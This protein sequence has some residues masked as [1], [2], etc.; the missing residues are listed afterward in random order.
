[1][2]G[3]AK[4]LENAGL[5]DKNQIL[6]ATEYA[7]KTNQTFQSSIIR[8]GFLGFEKLKPMAELC[9]GYP[10][11]TLAKPVEHNL[12]DP[13]IAK[14]NHSYAYERNNTIYLIMDDPCD[15]I[16]QDRV[17]QKINSHLPIKVF[18][19]PWAIMLQWFDDD[20]I[21]YKNDLD[22]II[23]NALQRGATDIHFFCEKYLVEVR[24]RELGILLKQK[25]LDYSAYQRL[26]LQTKMQCNLDIVEKRKPQSGS[27]LHQSFHAKTECR[28]SLHPAKHGES[29]VIRLFPEG[30]KSI[31]LEEL[32]FSRGIC[33]NLRELV[34][35][36]SGLIIVAGPTGGGKSTTLHALIQTLEI[37]KLNVMT[38]EQPV[39]NIIAG[40]RQTELRD[41]GVMSYA[42]GIR[43]IL[44]HD[45]DVMLIGEI[46]D[47]DTA[48]MAL[49]AT[50]TGHL[51]LTTLHAKD[52]YSVPARLYDLGIKPSMLSGQLLAIMHQSLETNQEKQSRFARGDL[53]I[54]TPELD[55]AIAYGASVFDLKKLAKSH[56]QNANLDKEYKCSGAISYRLQDSAM[57]PE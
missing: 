31:Q 20:Q 43:S 36:K 22:T 16:T 2:S 49:R 10:S 6:L 56:W 11:S 23:T 40:I 1:M 30:R 47:E 17:V 26:L 4:A 19:L 12:L 27:W 41:N 9:F 3:L 57:D 51:V 52:V 39:E 37:E 29:L 35:Q 5:L 42:D 7:L 48:K 45:P 50:L 18:F 15:I 32:G 46:R 54:I 33:A 34:C 21:L 14:Q 55:E 38:L 13:D 24:T 25:T 8:M 53:L 44:R 28:V